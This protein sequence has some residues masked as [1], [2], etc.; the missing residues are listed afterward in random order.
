ML[1]AAAPPVVSYSREVAP[2]LALHCN[3][4]HGEAGGL[5]TRSYADLMRGGNLGKVIAP[6]DPDGSLLVH[7]IEGK[8]GAEH[9]M[10]LGGA[11]LSADQVSTIRRWITEGA[12]QDPDT[13]KNYKYTL[14]RVRAARSKPLRV[15]CRVPTESYPILTVF[16][17]RTKRVLFTDVATIKRVKGPADAGRPGDLIH[18]DVRPG[19]NWP[20]WV[21]LELT[22]A[23]AE[24]D[25]QGTEFFVKY[26]ARP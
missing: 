22:V 8:R 21:Q 23:Y 7:F 18:W 15:F 14:P 13:T 25:P 3:S 9:R 6:G 11:P 20:K 26:G 24:A 1:F 16:D 17:P 4:C 10:P 12:K 19:R 5:S 2:I